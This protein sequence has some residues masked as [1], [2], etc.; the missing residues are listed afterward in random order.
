MF[1]YSTAAT[2][3]IAS[4][5]GML[6][7]P[8]TQTMTF[9]LPTSLEA[10]GAKVDSIVAEF[11]AAVSKSEIEIAL[12]AK[13]YKAVTFTHVDTSTGERCSILRRILLICFLRCTF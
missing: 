8:Y 12:K 2:S 9:N 7:C 10:Y 13:K 5:I 4:V 3:V 1:L 11:G 6:K